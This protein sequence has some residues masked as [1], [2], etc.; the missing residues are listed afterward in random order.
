MMLRICECRSLL[1][2]KMVFELEFHSQPAKS[3]T[4]PP[5]SLTMSATAPKSQ[6]VELLSRNASQAPAATY[7]ISEP[8]MR[9][10]AR[11]RGSSPLK[12]WEMCSVRNSVLQQLQPT[13][14]S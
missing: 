4:L 6:G 3:V 2:A 7:P 8:A 9:V 14:G 10:N 12:I 13:I 5:A 11:Q 1:E